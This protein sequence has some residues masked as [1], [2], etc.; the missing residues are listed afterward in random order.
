MWGLSGI[1]GKGD[2][3]GFSFFIKIIG[4]EGKADQSLF[5]C[6]H[7]FSVLSLKN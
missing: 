3:S 5:S 2:R 1:D 7:G 6:P 4:V